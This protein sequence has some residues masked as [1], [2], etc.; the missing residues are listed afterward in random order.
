L[1]SAVA[2][3]AKAK[4]VVLHV[5]ATAV[6]VVLISV[7]VTTVD[8]ADLAAIAMID[9]HVTVTTVA[10]AN[11]TTVD[12]AAIAMIDLHVTV[13][14]EAHANSTIA[15]HADHAQNAATDHLAIVMHVLHADPLAAQAATVVEQALAARD[16]VNAAPSVQHAAHRPV[17]A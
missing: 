3:I 11:S 8:L 2:K 14:T 5:S 12:L 17:G 10:H 1:K 9:H 16:H 7:T 15:D 4:V 6:A 13:T